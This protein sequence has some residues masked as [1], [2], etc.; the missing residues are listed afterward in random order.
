[1][2]AFKRDIGAVFPQSPNRAA[3]RAFDFKASSSRFLGG[4]FVSSEWIYR[5]EISAI[6]STAAR[7]AGSFAFDGLLK[8]LIFLTN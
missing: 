6:C 2:R 5:L 7:N 4:A 1:M 8:P 3:A